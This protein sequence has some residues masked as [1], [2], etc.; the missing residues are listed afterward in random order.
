MFLAG[1]C[2]ILIAL[3]IS[4]AGH[5]NVSDPQETVIED[6]QG[7]TMAEEEAAQCKGDCDTDKV[8]CNGGCDGEKNCETDCFKQYRDC[9]SLCK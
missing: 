3:S 1:A 5:P 8:L 6:L 7:A 4:H 2:S 9:V